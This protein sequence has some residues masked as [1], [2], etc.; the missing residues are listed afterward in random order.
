MTAPASRAAEIRRETKETS[1]FVRVDLDGSGASTIDTGIGFFDH[2]L[3]SLARHGGFDLTVECKGDLQI[4][5]H[6]TVEDT[7]I[8]L[9]QVANITDAKRIG[10]G[11]FARVN[12]ETFTAK[13]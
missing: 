5:A 4:D 6:H 8:V 11:D 12:D 2:M 3:D 10:A 9:K 13:T 1:I 7:G